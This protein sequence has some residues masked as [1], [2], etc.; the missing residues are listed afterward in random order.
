M[1]D[2]RVV[3]F[4]KNELK[5]KTGGIERGINKLTRGGIGESKR[6]IGESKK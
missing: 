4:W 3:T 5:F 2:M 6:G 1:Q